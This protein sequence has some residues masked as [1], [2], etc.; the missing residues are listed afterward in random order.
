[1][2][3]KCKRTADMTKQ[4]IRGSG[5]GLKVPFDIGEQRLKVSAMMIMGD[6]AT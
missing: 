5:E 3:V 2:L 4:G 6:D 1:M